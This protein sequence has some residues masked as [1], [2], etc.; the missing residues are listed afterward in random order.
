MLFS[1][2]AMLVE[3]VWNGLN[4]LS[5]MPKKIIQTFQYRFKITATIF[6][7]G[8][9]FPFN[10]GSISSL[11]VS[12]N[13]LRWYLNQYGFDENFLFKLPIF[14][15]NLFPLYQFR[16]QIKLTLSTISVIKLLHCYFPESRC[17]TLIFFQLKNSHDKVTLSDATVPLGECAASFGFY[18]RF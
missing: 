10:Q 9:S 1:I 7:L 2:T 5:F 16:C 4:C 6:Q 11:L 15:L 18:V 17:S 14:K 13:C 3:F 8:F 12:R